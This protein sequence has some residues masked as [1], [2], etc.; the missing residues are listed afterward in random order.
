MYLFCLKSSRRLHCPKFQTTLMKVI[1]MWRT[2]QH[3]DVGTV[4]RAM[5]S[6]LATFIVFLDLSAAFDSVDH[7]I[8]LRRLTNKFGFTGSVISW[9]DSYLSDRS[10]RMKIAN[11]FSQP[12]KLKFGVPQGSVVG[13]QL[14]SLYTNPIAD[15]IER[16]PRIQHHSYA[17]D[18]QLYI[19]ADPKDSDD[20][21][22]A[23]VSLSLCVNDLQQWMQRNMLK[24]NCE[25]TEFLVAVSPHFSHLVSDITLAIGDADIEPSTTVRSLGVVLD[26][27]LRMNHHVSSLSSTLHFHLSNIA[28]IRPYLD[29][30]ACEHAVRA[31]VTSRTDYSNSL[32]CNISMSNI[33][34]LQR[35]QNRAAK[36][37]FRAKKHDHASPFLRQ[38]HWLPIEKRIT[39]KI[40]TMTYKCIHQ[41]A[42][43]YLQNLLSLHQPGRHGLRSGNDPTLLSVPR[44]PLK[45]GPSR[46]SIIAPENVTFFTRLGS[47]GRGDFGGV[48]KGELRSN[49]SQVDVAIREIPVQVTESINVLRAVK[50]LSEL[51]DQPNVV[52][53]LGY[54]QEQGSILYEF[55]SRGTLLTHLQTTGV[56]SLPTY[57]NLKPKRVRIDEGSLLNLAW[58]TAK[59]MQYLTSKKII[60]G[61]LCAHNVLLSHRKQCKLSDYGLSSSLFSD[62]RKPTRWS[63]PETMVTG[64]QSTYG[65]IW[66]FGIVLWEIVTLGARPY[67]NM[68]FDTVQT[69][70][71]NGYR[72]PR[73]RHCGQ[74]VYTIMSGCWEKEAT[75]RSNF[76]QILESLE[77]IL[78][79][80]H[81]YL[82]LNDLDETFY[83]STLDM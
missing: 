67:P 48:W 45:L 21:R 32:L 26:S 56:Q 18:V 61:T 41:M 36:L 80:T 59:G 64:D 1:Y 60:H 55:I 50:V 15:I 29:K 66:S 5:D 23:L 19:S 6:K 25:K 27:S 16:R 49:Q 22:S 20:V 43:S 42:P 9:L 34:R 37:V 47:I 12:R 8:L 69:E 33:N 63:S 24:L 4:L 68:T 76:D 44:S 58:Q 30:S 46:S 54:C 72:M 2:S 31:L 65:D 74:E 28:R 11:D 35:A 7:E 77:R 81:N 39:Y 40:L 3:T 78:E 52:K 71:A 17:D 62:R 82:S 70:V 75:N 51:P 10:V 79:K 73:P 13:P 57:G 14:F 38:L 53:C 83:A